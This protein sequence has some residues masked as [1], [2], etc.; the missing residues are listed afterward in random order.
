MKYIHEAKKKN[1][2][3]SNANLQVEPGW[4]LLNQL[5]QYCMLQNGAC[6]TKKQ[7]TSVKRSV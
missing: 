2:K 4:Q 1:H 6:K 3:D 7:E 5:S